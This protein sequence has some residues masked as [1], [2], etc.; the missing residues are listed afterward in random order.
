MS[1]PPYI[2]LDR[3]GGFPGDAGFLGA[4]CN[5]FDAEVGI[6]GEART[7]DFGLPAGFTAGQLADRNQLRSAFDKKFR[8]LDSADLPAS[9]DQ[10]QLRA[11]D[12]LRSD[13]VRQAFDLS[14][15]KETLRNEYGASSLGRCALTA[16]RLIESG[17]RFVTIGMTG[18]DTHGGGFRTLRQQLLPELDR[19]L[20]ALMRDLQS[21]SL[22]DRTVVYCAGEFA[23]TPRVNGNAGRDHWPRSMSVL[24]AGGGVRGGYI[25]GSTDAY[26]LAPEADPCSPADVSATVL[27]LLGLDP[28][29]ELRT[30]SGRPVA[31]FREGKVLDP[32]IG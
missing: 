19:V 9:L 27:H 6:R 4:A 29:S 1:I 11:V 8:D 14:K 28:T 25:H 21:R 18:W 17:A 32:L 10:F 2:S 24:L 22:L 7:G 26:G 15:E 16:R 23:R 12:I 13:R 31:L 3:A 30:P 5:P 20:A